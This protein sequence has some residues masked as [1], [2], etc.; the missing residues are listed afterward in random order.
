MVEVVFLVSCLEGRLLCQS[1]TLRCSHA[2]SATCIISQTTY[3]RR[4]KLT[5]HWW[6]LLEI[7]MEPVHQQVLQWWR[8][9]HYNA[10]CDDT[11]ATELK[12][13]LH[14]LHIT[15]FTLSPCLCSLR[16]SALFP[17]ATRLRLAFFSKSLKCLQHL[18]FWK[19]QDSD[20]S[21]LITMLTHN[22][23]K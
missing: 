18:L 15:S 12:N 11:G 1:P 21:L 9:I 8:K 13:P 6:W 4:F 20:D 22:W 2:R 23:F 16:R 5:F 7:A 17:F 19:L 14:C 10:C 3:Y